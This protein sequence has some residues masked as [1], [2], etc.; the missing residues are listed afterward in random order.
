MIFIDQESIK[1]LTEFLHSVWAP[2]AVVV[3]RSLE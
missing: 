2:D 3:T 1:G